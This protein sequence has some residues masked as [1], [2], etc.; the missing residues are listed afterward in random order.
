MRKILLCLM[1]ALAFFDSR[2]TNA[3][4]VIVCGHLCLMACENECS[5]TANPLLRSECI[6]NCF[7]GCYFA[8]LDRMAGS[9]P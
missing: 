5:A 3:S 4:E 7:V 1:F 6:N 2:P 9:Y 8:C